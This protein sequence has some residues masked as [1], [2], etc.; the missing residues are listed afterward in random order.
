[1]SINQQ[2]IELTQQA[3]AAE[4]EGNFNQARALYGQVVPL[5]TQA[6]ATGQKK[7]E[8]RRKAKMHLRATSDRLAVLRVDV[9]GEVTDKPSPLP[10]LWTFQLEV[11]RNN[12][13]DI[14][15]LSLVRVVS[16]PIIGAHGSL[17]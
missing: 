4:L 15:L 9:N 7:S 1:M 2:A 3:H 14:V 17:R 11:N 10:S 5:L 8:E 13:G 6:I 16:T 12:P